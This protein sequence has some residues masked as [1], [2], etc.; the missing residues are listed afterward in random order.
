[1][2]GSRIDIPLILPSYR[3]FFFIP[4]TL[5]NYRYLFIPHVL[6]NLDNYL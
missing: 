2:E 5:P 4:H 3:H 1:M 6:L